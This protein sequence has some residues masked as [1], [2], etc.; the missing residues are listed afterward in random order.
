MPSPSYYPEL[1]EFRS[2]SERKVFESLKENLSPKDVIICNL[3]ITDDQH[4]DVE[5]DFVVLMQGFGIAVIEAKGGHIYHDGNNWI[6]QDSKGKRKIDP[7]GQAKKNLYSLK[8]Y[9]AKRWSQRF[10]R[11]NWL[12]AF[13]NHDFLDVG[14]PVLPYSKVIDRSDLIAP[15]KKLRDSILERGSI[16]DD[17]LWIEAALRVLKPRAQLSGDAK[18]IVD[19]NHSYVRD[20]THARSQLLDSIK[21][22]NRYFISGPAGS[23][24]TW[25]AVEQAKRWTD[26]GMDVAVIAFNRGL[27]SYLEQKN[28]ERPEGLRFKFVGTFHDFASYLGTY[29]GSPSKFNDEDEKYKDRLIE[30]AKSLDSSKRFNAIVIDEAQDFMRA[31]WES[32]RLSLKDSENGKIAAFGDD[33]QQLNGRRIGPLYSMMRFE[34]RENV[35]NS[36]QIASLATSIVNNGIPLRGPSAFEII[37]VDAPEGAVVEYADDQ[38]SILTDKENWRPGE[39][40]LLTIKNRHQVQV[41]YGNSR[42]NKQKYWDDFWLSDQVFYGTVS[43]FKGLER[44]AVVLAIDGFHDDTDIEDVLYVGCTRARDKL[45]IVGTKSDLDRLRSIV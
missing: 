13:P 28:L 3:S 7:A 1:P 36:L 10:I 9:L 44:P 21:L 41:D 18:E 23:G 22:N 32:A 15:V 37:F 29:A 19:S 39:V 31:W 17:D 14:D 2:D 6:Q 26:E 38:V 12:V 27:V 8:N 20:L 11:S 33:Q 24:K 43:G 4:G 42:Q 45:I 25:M 35:R 40:A 30:A 5:L 16:P 34:I